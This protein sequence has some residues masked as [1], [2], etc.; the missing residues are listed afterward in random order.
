MNQTE[1]C[2]GPFGSSPLRQCDWSLIGSLER[3]H[4]GIRAVAARQKYITGRG[5]DLAE[6]RFCNGTSTHLGAV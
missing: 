1:G 4:L 5:V 6:R 3:A 2:N